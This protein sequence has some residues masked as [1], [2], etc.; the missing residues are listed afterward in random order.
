MDVKNQTSIPLYLMVPHQ[1]NS[2]GRSFTKICLLSCEKIKAFQPILPTKEILETHFQAE[3]VRMEIAK[4]NP[5]GG[6]YIPQPLYLEIESSI[7]V[8][9]VEEAKAKDA[10]ISGAQTLAL[11]LGGS[12]PCCIIS[13]NN[14]EQED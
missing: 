14:L 10:E 4:N 8:S 7:F 1:V 3:R 11:T 2:N 13:P 12:I 6:K 5:E 9:I